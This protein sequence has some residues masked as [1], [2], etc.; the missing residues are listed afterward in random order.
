MHIRLCCGDA[1]LVWF[2][3]KMVRGRSYVHGRAGHAAVKRAG[4]RMSQATDLIGLKR[5]C[6]SSGTFSASQT[7]TAGAWRHALPCH[8]AAPQQAYQE[9]HL[10]IMHELSSHLF[11]W[12]RYYWVEVR[13]TNYYYFYILI[14]VY[15]LFY[16]IWMSDRPQR[17]NIYKKEVLNQL[18]L[19]FW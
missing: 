17:P 6:C 15:W 8:Q 18:I 9:N 4:C 12:M 1:P 5:G 16:D 13:Q 7:P 3:L 19:F 2:C 11:T 14:H 10:N